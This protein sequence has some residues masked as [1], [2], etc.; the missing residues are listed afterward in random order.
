MWAILS[1]PF[2]R[3]VETQRDLA[4]L[5]NG[6]YVTRYCIAVV[7]EYY[8]I[9]EANFVPVTHVQTGCYVHPDNVD[10]LVTR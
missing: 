7:E 9:N 5:R 8:S 3:E 2:G 10:A 4:M 6:L 1:S